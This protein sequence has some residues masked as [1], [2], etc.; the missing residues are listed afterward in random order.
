MG[1]IK[2]QGCTARGYSEYERE[3]EL[4]IDRNFPDGKTKLP[5]TE[6]PR[7]A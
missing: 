1:A 3:V 7:K 4:S 2:G 6:N 5:L